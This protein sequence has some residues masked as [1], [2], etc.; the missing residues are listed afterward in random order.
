MKLYL[1][2]LSQVLRL[3][4]EEEGSGE[5][6]VEA[7]GGGRMRSGGR[8][9]KAGSGGVAGV[10]R[11]KDEVGRASGASVI[12]FSGWLTGQSHTHSHTCI[13]LLNPRPPAHNQCSQVRSQWPARG[14]QSARCFGATVS[15]VFSC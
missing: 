12:C 4:Q 1:K 14:G 6:V 13:V 2:T 11:E 15:H 3:R 9:K 8:G 7:D 10:T 5:R